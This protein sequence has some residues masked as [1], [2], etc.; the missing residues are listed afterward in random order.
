MIEGLLEIA[1]KQLY[2]IVVPDD[3]I[4]Q[5]DFLEPGSPGTLATGQIPPL[6]STGSRAPLITVPPER[7]RELFKAFESGHPGRIPVG[8]K[9]PGGIF[10]PTPSTI[11]WDEDMEQFFTI[12]EE[13]DRILIDP[14]RLLEND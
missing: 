5:E 7:Q 3:S 6:E 10:T 9:T 2:P 1:A 8:A 14:D 12:T 4:F 13:G 11:E